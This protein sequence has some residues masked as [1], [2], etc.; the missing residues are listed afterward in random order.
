MIYLQVVQNIS[1][2]TLIGLVL[3]K[4]RL[5]MHISLSHS[6]AFQVSSATSDCECAR[7]SGLPDGV[8]QGD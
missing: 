5:L 4:L 3:I 7:K 2:R 8:E 6:I 1:M